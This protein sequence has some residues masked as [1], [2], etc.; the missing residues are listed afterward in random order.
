MTI[1]RMT[2]LVVGATGSIG[3]LVVEEAIRQGHTVHA[4]VRTPVKA[5]QLPTQ[6]QVFI[7]DITRP[8]TLPGAVDGV[9]AVVF[10]HGSDDAGKVGTENVDYG[11]VRNVLGALGSRSARI[12]LMTTIGVTNRTGKYNQTTEAHAWKRR[13]ERL[14]RA[15]GLP[16]TITF[17][18][19]AT[20]GSLGSRTWSFYACLGC[21]DSAG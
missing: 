16:Y 6:A 2:V 7:G 20:T 3:L 21:Y 11:G 15:S 5:R 17:P 12:A 8:E 18:P 10:T 4:P 19:Q 14:V 9:D 13:P 1:P